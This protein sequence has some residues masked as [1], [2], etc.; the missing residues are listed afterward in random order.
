VHEVALCTAI[1]N[2]ATRT[3]AGQPVERVRVEIGHLRQVV[4]ETLRSCWEMV[5]FATPLEAVPLEVH[6]VPAL[7][8]CRA[9]TSTTELRE[10]IL[11]CAA[12]GSTDTVVLTGD[13]LNVT[14]I[15]VTVELE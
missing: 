1:A 3:A 2:V 9:C 13:E 12:C 4:P 8:E 15:D 6:E 10:P 7:I 11:V 14:S 5:V